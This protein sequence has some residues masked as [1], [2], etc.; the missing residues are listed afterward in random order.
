[1]ERQE[2]RS[3]DEQLLLDNQSI[4]M[5]GIFSCS[6]PAQLESSICFARYLSHVGINATNYLLFLRF[7]ETNNRW[8]IDA[9][10]GNREPRLL[11][12]GIRPNQL[13]VRKAFLLLSAWHP[14]QIYDKVLQAVLGIIEYCYHSPDD[15]FQIYRLKITDLNNIGKF[16]DESKDQFDDSNSIL[17]SVLDRITRMGAFG[18]SQRKIVLSKHAFNIRIAFFDNQKQCVDVIPQLLMVRLRREDSETAPS[19]PFRGFLSNR[20]EEQTG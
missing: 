20:K 5:D 3:E 15:G 1:M 19:R 9:L 11:F 18:E 17:L 4:I 14:G 16:L 8:V 2:K 13:L 6:T 10:V 7:L 12:S